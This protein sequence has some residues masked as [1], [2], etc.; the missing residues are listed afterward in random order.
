MA[1]EVSGCINTYCGMMYERL[2]ACRCWLADTSA[3]E[4]HAA[5]AGWQPAVHHR[6]SLRTIIAIGKPMQTMIIAKPISR[7]ESGIGVVLFGIADKGITT[8]FMKA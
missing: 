6:E 1:E 5:A 8:K 3:V 4:L 2:P 7:P